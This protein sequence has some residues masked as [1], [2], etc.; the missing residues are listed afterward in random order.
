M[1]PESRIL[2]LGLEIFDRTVKR[3]EERVEVGILQA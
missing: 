3:L 2:Y 1:F